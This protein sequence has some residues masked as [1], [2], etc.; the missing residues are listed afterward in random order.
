MRKATFL[1]VLLTF[2]APQLTIAASGKALQPKQTPLKLIVCPAHDNGHVKKEYLLLVDRLQKEL[3]RRVRLFGVQRYGR[4]ATL[5]R[6]GS[7][8]MGIVSLQALDELDKRGLRD[9]VRVVAAQVL[10]N[11]ARYRGVVVTKSGNGIASMDDLAGKTLAIPDYRSYSAW[12][13]IQGWFKSRGVTPSRFLGQVEQAGGHVEALRQ[14]V[15][16][17]VDAAAVSSLTFYQAEQMGMDVDQLLPIYKTKQIPFDGFCVATKL[18]DETVRQIEM[19][20]LA[21]KGRTPLGK[22]V[23]EWRRATNESYVP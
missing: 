8:D 10:D 18:D 7:V 13:V 22:I 17:D 5:L 20:V 21:F 1:I 23:L 19:A 9:E 15:D 6:R 14:L 3:G 11:K 4:F 16:D 12:R 2:L